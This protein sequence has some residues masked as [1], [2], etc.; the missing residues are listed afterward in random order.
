MRILFISNAGLSPHVL[1]PLRY[2][3]DNG[4]NVTVLG[5][6]NPFPEGRDRFAHIAHDNSPGHLMEVLKEIGRVFAPEVAHVHYADLAAYHVV[7]SGIAPVVL[8]IWGSDIN[9]YV[10]DRTV[11]ALFRKAA[12]LL[13][14]D[15][16]YVLPRCAHV[17]VD[18]SSMPEKC[19]FLAPNCAPIE[20]LPLGVDTLRFRPPT[21]T[22]RLAAREEFAIPEERIA[23]LSSRAFDPLYGH[24]RILA[25]FFANCKTP[26]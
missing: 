10:P 5:A 8:S 15:L 24:D 25:A 26:P 14:R 18:D 1:R 3:L 20:I 13:R 16:T 21:S 4:H 22:E 17:I 9:R 11:P 12:A 23:L 2:L 6:V 7:R 19:R